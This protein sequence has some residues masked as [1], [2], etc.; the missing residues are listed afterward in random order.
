MRRCAGAL[1]AAVAT[2]LTAPAA[3]LAA[4]T[5]TTFT[6][7]ADAFVS[8]AKPK[9]KFGTAGELRI[10]APLNAQISYL[11]FDVRG[12]LGQ[13][14]R[15]ALRLSPNTASTAYNLHRVSSTNWNEQS[16][17][18]TNA[19]AMDAAVIG[20][21]TLAPDGW[22]EVDVTALVSGNGQISVGLDTTALNAVSLASRETSARA[23][24]LVVVTSTASDTAAPVVSLAQPVAGSSTSDATPLF[25]GG[26]GTDVGDLSS[27][28]VKVYSGGSAAGTPVLTQS[29]ARSGGSWSLEASPALAVGTYTARAD[30][31]AG[32]VGLSA[33][34]TFEV[35]ATTPGSSYPDEVMADSPRAYWRLGETSGTTAAS[36]TGTDTATYLNGP[37]LGQSGAIS[38]DPSPSVLLDGVNDTL[39]ASSSANLSPTLALSLEAWV[40]PAA[41]PGG[42]ATIVR[43]DLQYLLRVTSSGA[44]T[45]RLWKGGAANEF[46]TASNAVRAGAWNHVVASWNGAT[47]AIY[48]NGTQRASTALAAPSDSASD[49]FYIGSSGGGYD[50]LSAWVDE[51]AVYG[52]ALSSTRI[53]AHYT[54]AGIAP[55]GPSVQLDTPTSNST[56]DAT[57]NFGGNAGK[58]QGDSGSVTVKVYEGATAT[59]TPVRTL[60]AQVQPAGTFSVKPA[61][62]LASGTY[63]AQVEQT[64]SAGGIGR[65]SARTFTVDASMAPVMLAAGDIAACDTYGDEATAALLDGLPGTVVSVGD[66]VY[67]YATEPDFTNCY[68]PTWGRHKARTKPTIG[69][70]EFFQPG[71]STYFDY[72]GA[73]AGDRTKGYYSYD[74]GSWHVVSMHTYCT[75]VAGGCAAGSPEEQWLRSDLAASNSS[76]TLIYMHNP[77]FSSGKIHGSDEAMTDFWQAA[78]DH[79][80][81]LVVSANDHV[82]ERFAPQTPGGAADAA[83]G[84]RQFV[85]GMGG[86]SHYSFG[87]IRPNS[88][89]RNNDAFGVLKL[90][91]R[92]G[93]YD[94]Q[95]VPEAGKTFSDSGSTSCH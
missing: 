57:P 72:F 43:K 25:S 5:T 92:S 50:W 19:P 13:V 71:A 89:V 31:G 2:A 7:V 16:L 54:K 59:G 45:F 85:V 38:D 61:S 58:A 66:H 22:T 52:A 63:T 87:T 84:I 55:A 24:K 49:G 62:P 65:S 36:V 12:V 29:T 39:R 42:T 27:V 93:T 94:W 28:T 75:E 30:D 14:T 17:T 56:M 32:N 67:E 76:C 34:N 20:A 78:Y 8:Q 95:F 41:L 11:R 4:E 51:V 15:A 53:Q 26:A 69:D 18:W 70:H 60:T 10:A 91:L 47:M 9:A 23:P 6:P 68:D 46:S 81:E 21:S 73:A 44:V 35:T 88:Q 1:A 90:T 40:K 64:N 79:G 33:A 86:R 80:A 37:T 77:R 83:N 82:Y 74:V 3:G 48:I